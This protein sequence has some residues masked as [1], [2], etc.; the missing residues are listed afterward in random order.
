MT[1]TQQTPP[2]IALLN[3]STTFTRLPN[4]NGGSDL[5][6]VKITTKVRT[7]TGI[8]HD[9]SQGFILNGEDA[10]DTLGSLR[11]IHN[12]IQLILLKAQQEAEAEAEAAAAEAEAPAAMATAAKSGSSTPSLGVG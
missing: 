6:E 4:P 5:L 2:K 10:S 12:N 3:E 11:V 1:Q 7:I 8:V 9:S